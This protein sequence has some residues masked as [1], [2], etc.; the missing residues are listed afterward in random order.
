[1]TKLLL[2]SLVNFGSAS[3]AE[4]AAGQNKTAT[5]LHLFEKALSYMNFDHEEQEKY[6]GY[7]ATVLREGE[8]VAEKFSAN[9]ENGECA[10]I[11]KTVKEYVDRAITYLKDEADK[12]LFGEEGLKSKVLKAVD[13]N[14]DNDATLLSTTFDVL[15]KM[16]VGYVEKK[17][18]GEIKFVETCVDDATTN[19]ATVAGPQSGLEGA[20][21][22]FEKALRMVFENS[23]ADAIIS[24][25]RFV[26]DKFQAF[27]KEMGSGD[28]GSIRAAMQKLSGTTIEQAQGKA[29]EVAN[30]LGMVEKFGETSFKT[31]LAVL[32]A[33]LT[34]NIETRIAG[35]SCN[36]GNEDVH[37][38]N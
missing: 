13:A 10:A 4:P 23:R 27:I 29:L 7:L 35:L 2:F 20:L 8:E 5:T 15:E 17:A 26:V 3:P 1:M 38:D 33:Q 12:G 16:L 19:G 28:C 24:A 32:S 21:T 30:H 9:V 6:T 14:S 34:K 36:E 25:M 31:I 22:V 18:L 11:K 37:S